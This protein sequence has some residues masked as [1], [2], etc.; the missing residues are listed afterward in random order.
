MSA[1]KQYSNSNYSIERLL[2][3]DTSSPGTSTHSTTSLN[4]K[5]PQ[6]TTESILKINTLQQGWFQYFIQFF[7]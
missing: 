1:V 2:I 4:Q 6:G 7:L 5:W 3:S